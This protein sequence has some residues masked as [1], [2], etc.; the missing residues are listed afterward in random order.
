VSGALTIIIPLLLIAQNMSLATVGVV[1]SILPLVF[2]A[3]RLFFSALADYIGWSKIF[4]MFN[5]PS[6]V[7][8]IVIYYFASSTS[9]YLLGKIAEGARESSYWAVIRTAI[10][11][12]SS[13]KATKEATKNNAVVWIATA[14]GAAFAGLTVYKIGFSFSLAAL[15]L[16]SLTLSI[17]AIMLWKSNSKV[18]FPKTQRF[19]SF[20]DF[21]GRERIFWVGSLALMFNSLS[22]YPL[23]T[24]LLPV[25][26]NQ[27]LGF[28]YLTVGTLF[29]VYYAVSAVA[30]FFSLRSPL[31]IGR[32]AGLSC[33]S[34]ISSFLLIYPGILFLFALM[35]LAFVRGYAIGYFEQTI[36]SVT[37]KSRN[38]SVDI[39]FIHVPQRISEFLSLISAGFLAQLFGYAP[40][41]MLSALFFVEF[42]IIALYVIRK[43]SGSN[44]NLP[45]ES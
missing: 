5:W 29:M 41:F 2:L 44:I 19:I 26:M 39:G 45:K 27:Q 3:T 21:R 10:Y 16:I 1:L 18:S 32:A 31:S 36:V 4:L 34:V 30:A 6:T 23:A 17:P 43:S 7:L 12:L 38:I 8:S 22:A 24:L 33:L 20:F 15:A 25:F 42:L 14:A 28:D 37:K 11:N 9:I 35:A 40:V 13:E